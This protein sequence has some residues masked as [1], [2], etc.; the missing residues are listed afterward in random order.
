[1]SITA[2]V[3]NYER[4]L[5]PKWALAPAGTGFSVQKPSLNSSMNTTY[6]LGTSWLCAIWQLA[7]IL[8]QQ[9]GSNEESTRER[10]NDQAASM[11]WKK[12][13]PRMNTD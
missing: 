3:K 13:L 6:R 9:P 5:Q 11:R 12:L 7:N 4:F 1:M 8:C 10:N 2:I